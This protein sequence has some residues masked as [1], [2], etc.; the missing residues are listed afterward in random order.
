MQ[1]A[2]AD[3]TLWKIFT[4]ASNG[5]PGCSRIWTNIF[6]VLVTSSNI[7][8]HLVTSCV[9]S[10]GIL[11]HLVS[12]CVILWHLVASCDILWPSEKQSEEWQGLRHNVR[13]RLRRLL[14]E[15]LAVDVPRVGLRWCGSRDHRV[16]P[17]QCSASSLLFQLRN[18]SWDISVMRSN[19]G[20]LWALRENPTI[21]S[22]NLSFHTFVA[23]AYPC[24]SYQGY[25]CHL[26]KVWLFSGTYLHLAIGLNCSRSLR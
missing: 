13:L 2:H 3:R 25:H 18:D 15:C 10:C 14:S 17:G 21:N 12:S 8:W 4:Q 11:W 19:V 16:S 5:A 22:C 1:K 26:R 7:V 9:A 6:Q 20:K 23:G 24:L